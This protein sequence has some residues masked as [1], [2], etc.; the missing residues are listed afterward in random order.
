[1]A[2][3]PQADAAFYVYGLATV[4]LTPWVSSCILAPSV[5]STRSKGPPPPSPLSPTRN[6]NK[7]K[8][9]D[10]SARKELEETS[11]NAAITKE[12]AA[13]LEKTLLRFREELDQ[14]RNLASLSITLAAP[15]VN[16]QNPEPP[17]NTPQPLMQPTHNTPLFVPEPQNTIKDHNTPIFVDTMPHYSQPITSATK[18]DDKSSLIQN[19]VAEIKKLTSWVQGFEGNKGVEGLNYEDL[20]V[21][22][23]VELPEGYK[24]PKFEMFDGTGDPRVHLRMYCD[25]LVGVRRDEKIC[26]KLFMR[27]VKGDALSLYI[28]QDAKKW[29]SWVNMESDFMDRFRFNTENAP[30]VFYIQNLKKE[31]IETFREYA[32]RWRSEA[33]KVRPT[34]E[35]EQM[36]RFFVCAQ[37]PQYYER[38]MLIEGQKFSDIIKLG[39]RIE[40]G[41]K[42][43]MVTNL[44]ALQ[45]TNKALQSGGSSKKKDVNSV[46]VAQRN[47]SPMKYQTYPS[48]SLTYQPTL[49]YQEPSPTYQIPPPAYQSPLPPTYQPTSPRY[50]QPAP[51]Y[52]AYNSQPSHYPSPPTRQ[53]FPRPRLN[54]DRKPPRQ[55]TTIVEPIDQLYEKL[56]VAGYVT[57]IPVVTL[58]NPSQL[59]NPNKTCAYHS[60]M[61]GHTIDE[62]RSLKDK[63]QNLIDNK[64]IIAK[65]LAPNV[66]NNPLPDH[67]GRGIHM[68]EIEDEWDPKGSIGLIVERNEPKKPAVTLNPIVVQIQPSKGDVVNVSVPLEFEAPSAKAPKPIEVEF[69]IPKAPTPVEVTVLPPK[70][71][72]PVS[73]TDVTPF[74]TN[75]IPWDYTAE[76][77]RK[78]KTYTGEAIAA[79]GMTRTVRVYTPEHLAE[80]SKQASGRVVETG[81]DDLWRKVQDKEYS[82]VEQLNKTPAQ[83]SI[84]AL[85][86]S[87]EAY[88]NALMK[89]LTK[90]Y[91][92]SNI[93]R[94]EMANMV[95]QVLE[96]HKITFHEDELPPEGLGHNKALHITTQCEDHFITR[97]LVDGGSSL[98]ICPLITLRT[99]GKGLHEVKDGAIGVK[100]FDGSQ[101]VTLTYLDDEPTTVTCNE[102]MQQTDIDSEEDDILEEVVR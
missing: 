90:A 39:E 7:G 98:N 5:Y 46:M 55:Y 12:T 70:V 92:P 45:A 31:P 32:T 51:I 9:G 97:I 8:M 100:A 85:L 16:T 54:F 80:S 63:I 40:E 61:K 77:R 43:G 4:A 82:V 69:G 62:C 42:N 17:Q 49:N 14:V 52:Q 81:P 64:I 38:L 19:L 94:G 95:G 102:A 47:N 87:S 91:V 76:A 84:L 79:Q 44:E 74:K 34:L 73:M 28:S 75:V 36:N 65:E 30:D 26:M 83:I 27:S 15:D 18:S 25:K 11:Q 13:H 88:K 101:S 20:C 96:S 29:T 37:D 72:I 66:C 56:K 89:I 59:F 67:K 22:P 50:S 6:R 41:I 99:L 23:D 68:I 48:A 3:T 58:E 93:T 35:E 21:Q 1:M 33:A 53:N 10:A 71:P 24:S 86:Q 57:P 78:G 2:F 60:G